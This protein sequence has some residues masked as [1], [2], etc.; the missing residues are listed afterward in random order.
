M[1]ASQMITEAEFKIT[2]PLTDV[3]P[4]LLVDDSATA[5]RI[6]RSL[7]NEL[8]V[9]EVIELGAL[10]G[11]ASLPSNQIRFIIC[12]VEMSPINGIQFVSALKNDP[13]LN[14]VP[15]LLVTASRNINYARYARHLNVSGML[16]KPFSANSLHK[17]IKQTLLPSRRS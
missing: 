17:A 12:D 15:V 10:S 6:I 9:R 14:K 3:E 11:L 16:L 4:L 8:G 2:R 7:L 13:V 5:R 1:G